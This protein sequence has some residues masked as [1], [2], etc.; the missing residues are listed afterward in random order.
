MCIAV[1]FVTGLSGNNA[2]S[3]AETVSTAET[4]L[5]NYI[6]RLY[7][8]LA[9]DKGAP[10]SFEVFNKAYRGYLNLKTADRL[11]EDKDILTVCDFTQ[12]SNKDRM[13]VIDLKEK[14]VLFNT[15][16]AH[17]AATGE[18]FATK[19][20]NNFESHQSSLGFYVTGETY[21]GEHG[22][23]LR[24]HGM[25]YGFNHN[26]FDRAIV[27]HGADYVSKQFIK[28]NERL[29][30]SWGCPA[31]S[32]QLAQPIIN[33]IKGG[34][35]LFIYYPDKNYL[36]SGQWLN[37]KP[38]SIPQF[39]TDDMQNMLLSAKGKPAAKKKPQLP[40]KVEYDKSMIPNFYMVLPL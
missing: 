22:N 14:K 7:N 30:R 13:W 4:V 29:G 40:V 28:G 1:Y 6:K 34:T 20:S 11:S 38:E 9:F 16:V 23:S 5:A 2:A 31:V 21:T 12:S 17:G 39:V 10:L 37:K 27:M 33:T 26:A 32:N 8:E 18:E 25:D 3:A 36:K 19:F 24:L 15:Y 35:C